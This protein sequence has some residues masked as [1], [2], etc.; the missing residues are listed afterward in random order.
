MKNKT[1]DFADC[2]YISEVY[3]EIKHGLNLPKYCGSNWDAVWDFM[4]DYC[5]NMSVKIKGTNIL[6]K[7]FENTKEILIEILDRC[8]KELDDFSYKIIS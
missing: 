1:L 4:R 6:E 2:K 3:E 5:D 7:R 8:V